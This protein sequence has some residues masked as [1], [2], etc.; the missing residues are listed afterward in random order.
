MKQRGFTIVELLIV[1]VVIAILAAITIVA[2][3]GIQTR[4]RESKMNMD[5]MNISKAIQAAR[6]NT[7]K[8]FNQISGSGYSSGACVSKAVGTDLAALPASDT[9][10]VQY[11]DVL[12]DISVASGININNI[13]DPWGR[14]Y[15]IDENEGEN[16]TNCNPD[17]LGV[18]AQPFNGATRYPNFTVSPPKSGFTGCPI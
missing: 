14:P 15:F 6:N 16:G 13:V 11:F 8:T 17:V 18:F 5:L 12:N 10:W 4:A 9:C 1:I 3:N 2:Y 7:S